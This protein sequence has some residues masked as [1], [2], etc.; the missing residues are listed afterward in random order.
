MVARTLLTVAAVGLAVSL[1]AS[2]AAAGEAPRALSTPGTELVTH[3][4]SF[5]NEVEG[6]VRELGRQMR[7]T[8][9][10]ELRRE[11]KPKVAVAAR[12]ARTTT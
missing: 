9:N 4:Q 2:S 7:A 8:V 11:L 10:A 3:E 6:Y 1:L 5:R 12:E